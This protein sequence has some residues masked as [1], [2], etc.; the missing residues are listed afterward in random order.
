MN[1]R[2]RIWSAVLAVFPLFTGCGDL[3]NAGGTSETESE[4]FAREISV[5]SI[6]G[7]WNRPDSVATVGILRLDESNFDFARTTE[8]GRDVSVERLDG[9]ILPYRLVY[10]DR[11][12]R[13]GRI[14]VRLDPLLQTRGGRFM[15]RWG[16]PYSVRDD[17]AMVWKGIS[18]PEKLA[19]TSVLVDDFEHS[20]LQ[21]LL[22]D[23]STWKAYAADSATVTT[24]AIEDAGQGRAGKALHFGY[25]APKGYVLANVPLGPGPRSLRSLDSIVLWA[26][27]TGKVGV[28]FDRVPSGKSWTFR[29]LDTAWTRICI[30]PQDLDT[31]NNLGGNVGWDAVRDQISLL[32]LFPSGGGSD[33]WV[34]DIRLHGVNRDD[35]R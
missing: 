7:S 18:E 1:R 16:M 6:V 30:R 23:V 21:S 27:G 20:G 15:L 32:T 26:R 17:S 3:R 24:F 9:L 8:S 25:S 34:D 33:L 13:R 2:W 4:I 14:E 19:A 31:A 22:S 12:A 10:W 11:P 29:K 35:L 28:S 5:D